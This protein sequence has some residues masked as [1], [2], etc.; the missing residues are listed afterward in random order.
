[1][2]SACSDGIGGLMRSAGRAGG[3][4]A[5]CLLAS[6]SL[7]PRAEAS[8]C[9]PHALLE[10]LVL[11]TRR[12]IISQALPAELQVT[13][14]TRSLEE[15]DYVRRYTHTVRDDSLCS[16]AG[17]PSCPFLGRGREAMVYADGAC[18]HSDT[19]TVSVA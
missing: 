1:M 17:G 7:V 11:E 4:A 16:S 15:L 8:L 12:T 19:F 13:K 10:Y 9:V 6:L 5:C 2:T 3:V 14:A 18:F